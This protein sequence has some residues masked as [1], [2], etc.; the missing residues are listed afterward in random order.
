VLV[1]GHL[2]KEPVDLRP[3]LYLEH[4]DHARGEAL[5]HEREAII[6]RERAITYGEL[7]ARSV[8]LAN[9]LTGYGLGAHQDRSELSP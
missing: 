5:G 8:R 2:G 4:P 9:V 3:H 6:W 7:L 1:G